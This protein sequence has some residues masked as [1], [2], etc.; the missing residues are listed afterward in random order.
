MRACSWTNSINSNH[1][2]SYC[3]YIYIMTRPCCQ[4]MLGHVRYYRSIRSWPRVISVKTNLNT[5]GPLNNLKTWRCASLASESDSES[6]PAAHLRC[7]Y[8]YKDLDSENG[9]SQKT[10]YSGDCFISQRSE[11]VGVKQNFFGYSSPIKVQA[12]WASNPKAKK[13]IAQWVSDSGTWT[14][15]Y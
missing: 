15:R 12:G 6:R 8:Q 4:C 11:I 14:W 2:A 5:T 7:Y 3:N 10:D 1:H 13:K 9:I